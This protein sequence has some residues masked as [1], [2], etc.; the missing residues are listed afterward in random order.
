MREVIRD[1]NTPHHNDGDTSSPLDTPITISE[2]PTQPSSIL[3]SEWNLFSQL[4]VGD[5]LQVSQIHITKVQN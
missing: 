2:K 5:I 4:R 1:H 3:D